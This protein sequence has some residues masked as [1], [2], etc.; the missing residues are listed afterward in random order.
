MV[1]YIYDAYGVSV[2]KEFWEKGWKHAQNIIG[3]SAAE[4]EKRW[5]RHIEQ[6]KYEADVKWG[7]IKASG[8]E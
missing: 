5:R 7:K 1:Q 3:I 2:L 8:C 6:E 4:L